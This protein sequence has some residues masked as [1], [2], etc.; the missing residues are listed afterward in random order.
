MRPLLRGPGPEA[1]AEAVEREEEKENKASPVYQT[2][3]MGSIEGLTVHIASYGVHQRVHRLMHQ[4]GFIRGFTVH[5]IKW[6]SSE[7]SPSIASN[8]VHQRVHRLSHHHVGFIGH[9]TIYC[10]IWAS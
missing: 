8:G 4:M 7:G 10:T 6:G 5:C 2:C 3:I 9:S 1:D